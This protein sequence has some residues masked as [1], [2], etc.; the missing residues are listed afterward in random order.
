MAKSEKY[1]LSTEATKLNMKQKFH[2]ELFLLDVL[3]L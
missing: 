2:E 1:T 3:W